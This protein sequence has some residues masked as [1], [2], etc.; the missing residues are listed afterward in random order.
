MRA[1]AMTV[2]AVCLMSAIGVAEP[3]ETMTKS[4]K[5]LELVETLLEDPPKTPDAVK[6]M[7][8]VAL[9]PISKT[10]RLR[11][12][13]A[14]KGTDGLEFDKI[15]LS[16]LPNGD[17]G[18]LVF[19]IAPDLAPVRADVKARFDDIRITAAPRGRSLNDETEY[20]RKESWGILAFGF[21]ERDRD[22]LRSVI[23]NYMPKD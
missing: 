12:E 14:G 15:T 1:I 16:Y 2:G 6:K 11:D 19:T 4:D 21:A 7:L 23:F 22:K 5:Y 13:G 3:G 10:A 9:R 18:V 17:P 8:G 20:S